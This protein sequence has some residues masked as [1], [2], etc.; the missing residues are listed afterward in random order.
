MPSIDRVCEKLGIRH[1]LEQST[2]IGYGQRKPTC[3]CAVA[4]AS[5]SQ[6]VGLLRNIGHSHR[7]GDRIDSEVL[8]DI[9]SLLLCKG[10][11][12][13]QMEETVQGW[14]RNIARAPAVTRQPPA[15]AVL[16]TSSTPTRRPVEDA[17]TRQSLQTVDDRQLVREIIRRAE[18]A[19][20]TAM[21]DAI[22]EFARA[23]STTQPQR[24]PETA[25][26]LQGNATVS[27]DPV[28]SPQPP[29]AQI[30]ASGAGRTGDRQPNLRPEPITDHVQRNST[31]PAAPPAPSA[32][33]NTAP[34]RNSA[35]IPTT[36]SR[37]PSPLRQSHVECV[38]CLLPYEDGAEEHWE[39]RSCLNRVHLDCF[40]EWG[41]S[42]IASGQPVRCIHCR[43]RQRE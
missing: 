3:G 21:F 22:C 39:C 18:S 23:I 37:P 31:A 12:Q 16:R 29:R 32:T 17:S 10:W 19:Q 35:S 1:P 34:V 43:G 15:P 20:N 26:P 30:P 42:Q 5:R 4:Y 9:A 11:H 6:A 36:P 2:C 13:F 25:T 7:D 14:K 41:A 38:V 33:L 8:L 40:N 24:V 27:S 28:A